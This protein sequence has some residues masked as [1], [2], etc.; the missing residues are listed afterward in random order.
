ML[1]MLL[2]V[3]GAFALSGCSLLS[4]TPEQEFDDLIVGVHYVGIAVEDIEAS[5]QFYEASFDVE[6]LGVDELSL[7][8]LPADIVPASAT[9]VRSLLLRSANAQVRLMEFDGKGYQPPAEYSPVPVQ[10][11]GIM[12]VCFQALEEVSAYARA[13]AAGAK[14][15]GNEEPV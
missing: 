2:S 5:A 4:G 6:R 10:G 11:P 3:I 8:G 12:H 13:I 9:E 7:D 1:R 15:I 14:P